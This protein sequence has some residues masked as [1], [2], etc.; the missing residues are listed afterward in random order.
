MFIVNVSHFIVTTFTLETNIDF[1]KPS[2]ANKRPY[3]QESE[4]NAKEEAVYRQ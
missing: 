4:K 1:E 3:N 2:T